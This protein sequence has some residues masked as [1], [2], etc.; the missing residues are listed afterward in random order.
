MSAIR[1][2][3]A[4]DH[5]LMR[6]SLRNLLE[7]E[8][9]LRVVA[10]AG[11]LNDIAA[12]LAQVRPDV[13]IVDIGMLGRSRLQALRELREH[14]PAVQIVALA[15]DD[16]PISA[17][18]MLDGA[19]VA[20]V[21]K[22]LADTDLPAAVRQAARGEQF[23]SPQVAKRLELLRSA[24]G[25]GRLSAREVEILRLIALGHTSV[26]VA[27]KLHLSPRTIETHR[28]RIH[29]KLG[30][31]TRAELVRYALDHGLLRI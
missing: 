14:Q 4:D 20:F 24:S 15:T 13:L 9:D 30:L 21:L 6:R 17:G 19:A 18:R 23:V 31:D 27:R 29:N 3:V 10:E 12:R 1:V 28:A 5:V 16:D 7:G 8:P 26:E 2:L 25:E 11:E 22:E